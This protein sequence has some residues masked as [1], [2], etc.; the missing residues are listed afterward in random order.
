M[1]YYRVLSEAIDDVLSRG[2]VSADQIA[3]W[4]ARLKDAAENSLRADATSTLD[5]LLDNTFSRLVGTRRL[6]KNHVGLA[7][8]VFDGLRP[9][10]S[11]E[12]T[13]FKLSSSAFLK[14]RRE[15]ALL[16]SLRRFGGWASSIPP[17]GVSDR[18]RLVLRAEIKKPLASL[19]LQEVQAVKAQEANF[20][21]ALNTIVATEGEALAGL[22]HS[23]WRRPGYDYRPDHKENDLRVFLFRDSWAQRSGLLR[24]GPWADAQPIPGTLLGCKCHYV[25]FYTLES[26]PLEVLSAKGR[27]ALAQAA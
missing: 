13:K 23:Q 10:L 12:L 24:R 21:V 6:L 27:A 18:S 20:V 2:F 9:R 1:T 26:L 15:E 14:A 22:W 7:P 16:G 19:P 3:L 4:Q 8:A 11:T 17:G 5:R 25:Y